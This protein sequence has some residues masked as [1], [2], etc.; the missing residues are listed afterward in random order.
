M[1]HQVDTQNST[2]EWTAANLISEHHGNVSLKTGF[3]EIEDGKLV[4]GEFI[5]DMT[6]INNSD[7]PEEKVGML[8]KHLK[9][10]DFFNVEKFPEA[11]FKTTSINGEEVTGDF[12]LKGKTHP[13]TF[14]LSIEKETDKYRAT[15]IVTVDRTLWEIKYRSGKFFSDLGDATIKDKF[16]IS[17]NLITN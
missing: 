2:L 12:S 9:S 6:S 3:V 14:K 11:T 1:Q 4:S 7:L 8:V 13:L 17:L 10:E 5:I 16:Q 15:G